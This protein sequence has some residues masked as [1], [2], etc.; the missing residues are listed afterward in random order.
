MPLL[1]EPAERGQLGDASRRDGSPSKMVR[2]AAYVCTAG[3]TEGRG[4]VKAEQVPDVVLV[5]YRMSQL[6]TSSVA[7][8]DPLIANCVPWNHILTP[9]AYQGLFES[10][11]RRGNKIKLMRMNFLKR[12]SL[13]SIY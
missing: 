9:T 8:R 12:T 13:L 3:D 7:S 10:C 1:K 6:H 11:G 2:A 4:G 5:E